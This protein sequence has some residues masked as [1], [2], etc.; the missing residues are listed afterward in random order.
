MFDSIL[1]HLMLIGVLGIGSQWFAWRFRMPA[2]V[3]MSVAGLL[4]GPIF[5]WMNPAEDFGSLF[6]PIISVAVAI[7]L[8]EGSLNLDYREIKGLGKSV[9]RIITL[10][11]LLAWILGSLTAFFIAGLSW[12]VSFVIGGLFIVTG[13]TVILPLLRQA[14]LK[15]RPA[16]ILK[17]EGVVVDPLGALLAVFAFEI[18]QFLM[19]ESVTIEALVL[20][21]LASLFAVALGLGCGRGIGWM[22]ENGFVPEFLKSPIV[23][24]VVIAC[25]A[26]ADEVMHE[27]GLLAV[28][29]M[30]MTLANMHI[31][32]LSD[33]RHFKEN[34]S[35]LLISGIFIMITASLDRET[36]LQVFDPNILAYVILMLFVVRPL[37]IWLSTINTELSFKEK[38]LVGWIAPRGIVALTVANYFANVLEEAGYPGASIVTPLTFA[39]VFATVC[40]HGFTIGPLA[41]K[42]GL[43][44]EGN[45]G[46][47]IVGGSSF[48][49][50]LAKAL[51]DMDIPV[52]IT[53]TSFEQLFNA[54][55][56]GIPYY[57]GEILSEQTEYY[58]DMTPYEKLIAATDRDSYNSLVCTTLVP[59]IGRNDLFQLSWH[60]PDRDHPDDLVRRVGGRVLFEKGATFAELNRKVEEGYDFVRTKLTKQ[61]GYKKFLQEIEDDTLPLFNFKPTGRFDFFTSEAP[62]KPEAGD[63][64]VSLVPPDEKIV[65]PERKNHTDE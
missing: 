29:A 25:F 44:L 9:Y 63:T 10:G 21:F 4:I 43:S 45:P 62:L 54:R 20:F 31:A 17:W 58:L 65:E 42:L 35:V 30:G 8:F 2:I 52:L 48:T 59:E 50:S 11:A 22:F 53:D 1:S 16:A 38:A 39:L 49:T 14:K 32:S 23:F 57:R 6:N 56:V 61:Y 24:T 28:T 55:K 36:L 37:S 12:A 34:I 15:A 60:D 7:I 51:K 3:V 19:L 18:I 13:P 5:G 41:R 64:I 40:A 27:T 46:V 26:V 47:I 33:M